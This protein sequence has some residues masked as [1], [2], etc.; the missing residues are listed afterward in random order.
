MIAARIATSIAAAGASLACN[1]ILG[2]GSGYRVIA[3]EDGGPREC[4][5]RGDCRRGESC[6]LGFCSS[7]CTTD[8]ECRTGRCLNTDTSG[9][10][11]VTEE[12]AACSGDECPSGTTCYR[13]QC[14]SSCKVST[15]CTSDELCVAAT[16][17]VGTDVAHDPDATKDAG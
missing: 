1:S 14:R 9:A 4:T 2:I 16:A 7:P 5:A 12:Q 6:L 11:C 13:N 8:G 3:A 17:C 15:G 10:G